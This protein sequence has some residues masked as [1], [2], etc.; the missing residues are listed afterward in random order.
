MLLLIF[1]NA[2]NFKLKPFAF[3]RFNNQNI[4]QIDFSGLALVVVVVIVTVMI[5]VVIASG[6]VG[7]LLRSG[8]MFVL[9]GDDTFS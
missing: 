1:H 2:D 8:G 5:V 4:A 9:G 7:V 3:R 6:A